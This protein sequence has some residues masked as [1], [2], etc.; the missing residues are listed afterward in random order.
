MEVAVQSSAPDTAGRWQNNLCLFA[1]YDVQGRVADYVLHYLKE[2]RA[3]GFDIV[4]VSTSA[5]AQ[6]EVEK[7]SPLAVDIIIRE[8]TG[9]DF[10]SWM[11]AFKRHKGS[12]AG[13]LLLCN[14]S[15]YGPL[16]N[17]A[18]TLRQLIAVE[19]DFYGMVR[20]NEIEPHVQ[21]WFLLLTPRAHRS[22]TFNRFMD[23]QTAGFA[24]RQIIENFEVGLTTS[25]EAAGLTSHA[26]YDPRNHRAMPRMPV[27]PTHLLWR[28]LITTYGVPFIKIELLR[29]N[30]TR[31]SMS[32]WSK[33]AG[34]HNA[35]VVVHGKRHL[36]GRQRHPAM[37]ANRL[38]RIYQAFCLSDDFLGRKG[39]AWMQR[40]NFYAWTG[41]VWTLRRV[42]RLMGRV[43]GRA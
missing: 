25:L 42:R 31:V 14:D 9:H 15:V 2:I 26:L 21:S 24:K 33:V 40:A 28:R 8:N 18:A 12:P 34:A 41:A 30:P 22:E 37:R 36:A 13:L 20:S 43:D 6:E 23:S 35:E 29:D 1:H 11:E 10:G 39:W 38:A 27:N 17:L 32:S 4:F 7:L 16:W 3:A 19:A 5:L